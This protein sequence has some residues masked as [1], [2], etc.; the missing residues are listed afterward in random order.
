MSITRW[1]KRNPIE[2]TGIGFTLVCLACSIPGMVQQFQEMG[3][4]SRTIQR[5]AIDQ[6]RLEAQQAALAE[7]AKIADDRYRDG[8]LLIQKQGQN[9][10][11]AISQGMPVVDSQTGQ[12]L[13]PNTVICDF[14]G[15][16]AVMAWNGTAVV[17]TDVAFTGN[18]ELINQAIARSGIQLQPGDR[19]YGTATRTNQQ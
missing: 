15:N 10:L 18:R 6:Q 2:S 17:T 16:T 8:C 9:T 13:P 11:I 12:P 5:S 14:T 4:V 7:R 19:A 1:A 3:T